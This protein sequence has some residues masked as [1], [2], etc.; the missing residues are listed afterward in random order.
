MDYEKIYKDLFNKIKED[1]KVKRLVIDSFNGFFTYTSGISSTDN[2]QQRILIRKIIHDSFLLFRRP[3]LTTFLI[4]EK[5][6]KS[7]NEFNY[8]I[9]FMIDGEISME[10]ISFGSI[11]RRLFIPKM[12]WTNQYESSLPFKISSQ[13]LRIEKSK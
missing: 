3:D 6:S 9:S 10:Y 8:I 7:Q 1:N 12:R 11:E 13:G 5:D 4:L 2:I